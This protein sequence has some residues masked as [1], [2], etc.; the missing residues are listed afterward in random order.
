MITKTQI[1]HT[2]PTGTNSKQPSYLL[3]GK[4]FLP[5]QKGMLLLSQFFPRINMMT[6][7]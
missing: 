5:K 3:E 6:P 2:T 7:H 4:T 1:Q